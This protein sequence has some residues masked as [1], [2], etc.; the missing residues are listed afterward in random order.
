MQSFPSHEIGI[1]GQFS[2]LF[3]I[4]IL[5]SFPSHII[6]TQESFLHSGFILQSFPSHFIS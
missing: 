3:G 4:I 2:Q 1:N 5:Q 6:G